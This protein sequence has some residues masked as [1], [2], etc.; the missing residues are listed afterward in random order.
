MVNPVCSA[1]R[2]AVNLPQSVRSPL[3][4]P[5]IFARRTARK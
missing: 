3:Q 5:S 4:L 2:G 1:G